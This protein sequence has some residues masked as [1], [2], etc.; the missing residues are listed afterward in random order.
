MGDSYFAQD[1]SN[2]DFV[3]EKSLKELKERFDLSQWGRIVIAYEPTW[4][5]GKSL[6]TE[7]EHVRK[8][9]GF[10]RQWISTNVNETLAE[11]IR[12]IYAGQVDDKMASELI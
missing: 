10:I 12:I 11:T 2:S 7:K 5:H 9:H 4:T 6:G 1:T 8:T 3:I